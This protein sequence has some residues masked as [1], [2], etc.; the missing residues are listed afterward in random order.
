MNILILTHSYPDAAIKWRGL[1]IK[2]QAI[3]LSTKHEVI[4]VYFKVDYSHLAPFSKYSFIQRQNGRVTEYEITTRKSFPV[5]N[6]FKYLKD[7]YKFIS[8]EILARKKIDIIH[9]HLSYPGGFLGTIIQRRKGIP[10]V[11]TEHSWINKYFR[12]LIHKISVLYTLNHSARVVAVSQALK[13]DINHYSRCPVCVVPNVVEMTKFSL[14]STSRKDKNLNAGIL[15]GMGNYRKGLDILIKALPLLKDLELT[16]HIGGDGKLLQEFKDI[17]KE[18]DAERN[19]IFYGE[20]KPEAIFDFYSKLDFYILPSRDET[21]GVVVVE[22][23]ACGL[24]VIATRCGGPEEIITKETGILIEKENPAELA[25]AIRYI[26]ANMDSY[27]RKAIRDY[28]LDKYSPESFVKSISEVY[29]ELP[30][31]AE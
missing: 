6:Q 7:T 16:V 17:A 28:V 13:D 5:I 20:I 29:R 30:E 22:A 2:D 23:M 31:K 1:F 26:T 10:C 15:G 9:S 11:L 4:V 3:A 21:F 24:P 18:L 14:T 27:D 25:V 12:S 19:C 8:R